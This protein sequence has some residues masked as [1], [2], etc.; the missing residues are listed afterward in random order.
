MSTTHGCGGSASGYAQK[1]FNEQEMFR[2]FVSLD[3]Y[4]FK[5]RDTHLRCSFYSKYTA[6]V[7]MFVG[8]SS[9]VQIRM[10]NIP[11]RDFYPALP[12]SGSIKPS[13]KHHVL[14]T[15][16]FKTKTDTIHGCAV[17]VSSL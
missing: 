12:E 16:L 6:E 2:S 7:S 17:S 3:S 10:S 11:G 13:K 14:A 9:S 15:L 1:S 4:S 8:F 5:T